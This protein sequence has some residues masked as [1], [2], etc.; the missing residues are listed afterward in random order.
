MARDEEQPPLV[1]SKKPFQK[2]IAKKLKET[3]FLPQFSSRGG[4]EKPHGRGCG[5]G[6]RI[7]TRHS[8]QQK[9]Q[10]RIKGHFERVL[11]ITI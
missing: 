5:M 10:G 1:D 8:K 2:D 4:E 3:D 6:K 7:D 11:I 9:I